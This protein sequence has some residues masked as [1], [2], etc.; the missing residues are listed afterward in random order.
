[1]RLDEYIVPGY[2]V[3][4]HGIKPKPAEKVCSLMLKSCQLLLNFISCE[5]FITY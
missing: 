5:H 3:L 2:I 1:M 4:G